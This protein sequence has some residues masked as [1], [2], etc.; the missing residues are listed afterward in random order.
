MSS[1]PPPFDKPHLEVRLMF[2]RYIPNVSPV[3]AL[4]IIAAVSRRGVLPFRNFLHRYLTR[5]QLFSVKTVSGNHTNLTLDLTNRHRQDM[6]LLPRIPSLILCD[7]LWRSYRGPT[8]ILRET[9]KVMSKA[10][11][12]ALLEREQGKDILLRKPDII[13]S[14]WT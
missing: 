14:S 7:T 1:S 11:L 6:G 12:T 9:A 3:G 10:P 13:N 5:E 4:A 2:H 8:Q